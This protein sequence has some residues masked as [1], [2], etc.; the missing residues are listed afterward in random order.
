MGNANRTETFERICKDAG[1]TRSQLA[2]VIARLANLHVPQ[3]LPADTPTMD[4]RYA[5][6]AMRHYREILQELKR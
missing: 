1:I 3:F 5:K 6:V 4:I 2:I